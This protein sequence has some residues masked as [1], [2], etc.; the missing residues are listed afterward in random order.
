MSNCSS[1]KSV[2]RFSL[3]SLLIT[4]LFILWAGVSGQ[5]FAG[6]QVADHHSPELVSSD[7]SGDSSSPEPLAVATILLPYSEQSVGSAFSDSLG[8]IRPPRRLLSYPALPQAP[9]F[10]V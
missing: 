4:G 7:F 2:L 1:Q 3:Y 10:L 5:T 6:E 9:P 8:F